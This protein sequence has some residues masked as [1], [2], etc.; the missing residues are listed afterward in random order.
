MPVHVA[1]L[2][3][4]RKC[5]HHFLREQLER[6]R[7]REVAEENRKRRDS[8]RDALLQLLDQLLRRTL[9]SGRDERLEHLR[10]LPLRLDFRVALPDANQQLLRDVD[11]V[12]VAPDVFAMLLEHVEFVLEA[13]VTGRTVPSIGEPRD[14]LQHDLFAAAANRD[15]WM[16]LLYRLGI[17][18]RFIDLVV[19]PL[20]RRALLGE[21]RLHYMEAFLEHLEPC[22]HRRK[23]L[24]VRLVLLVHPARA[25]TD[26][27]TAVADMVDSRERLRQQRWI[28]V[29]VA[30]NEVADANLFSLC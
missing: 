15:R 22:A 9:D 4:L 30:Y 13:F 21:H 12:H 8:H 6:R 2:N 23:L 27:E 3:A 19:A 5:R 10:R 17:A 24:A 29:R 14:Q 7:R 16:R 11:R 1:I 26:F 18:D 25:V 28:A 20:K